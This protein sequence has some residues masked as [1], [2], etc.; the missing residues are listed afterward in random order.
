MPRTLHTDVGG[1]VYHV[2]NRANAGAP[3]FE[4]EIDCCQFTKLLAEERTHTGMRLLAWC[5][6]LRHWHLVL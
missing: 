3:L 2:L 5:L 1:L 6:L 4:G